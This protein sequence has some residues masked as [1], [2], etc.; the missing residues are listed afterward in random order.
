VLQTTAAEDTLRALLAA[1]PR[2][3]D[4]EVGGASLED[5]IQDLISKEAA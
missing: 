1:D 5:A 2:V 3:A 4:L